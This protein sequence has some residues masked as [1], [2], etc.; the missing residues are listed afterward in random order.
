MPF[1]FDDYDNVKPL[2]LIFA[3]E[4]KDICNVTSLITSRIGCWKLNEI[5][6][7]RKSLPKWN[8]PVE[9]NWHNLKHSK[10]LFCSSHVDGIYM[11]RYVLGH[12]KTQKRI[13][14]PRATLFLSNSVYLSELERYQGKMEL[15][16]SICRSSDIKR[17]LLQTIIS[18]ETAIS[19]K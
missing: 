10:C 19:E 9:S 1:K 18:R 7:R 16:L 4:C 12:K 2:H 3:G 11:F 15:L 14:A 17:Y 8:W 6:K 5:E 13:D